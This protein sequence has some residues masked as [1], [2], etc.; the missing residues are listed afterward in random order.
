MR[1]L[2]NILLVVVFLGL[3]GTSALAQCVPGF[4]VY[5]PPNPNTYLPGGVALNAYDLEGVL[6]NISLFL[7]FAGPVIV[8]IYIIWAGVIW[9]SAGDDQTKVKAAKDKLKQGIIGGLIIFG[10]GVIMETIRM[11]V[12]DPNSIF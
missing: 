1:K 10:V 3:I 2:L 9:T 11:F 4:G 12:Q 7:M 8:V 6:V 5:C